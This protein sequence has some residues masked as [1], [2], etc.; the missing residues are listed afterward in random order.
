MKNF[1]S[2]PNKTS[3]GCYYRAQNKTLLF[4]WSLLVLMNSYCSSPIA[5]KGLHGAVSPLSSAAFAGSFP[6][7]S[8]KYFFLKILSFIAFL[9]PTPLK[10]KAERGQHYHKANIPRGYSMSSHTNTIKY[11][12]VYIPLYQIK[13]QY[14]FLISFM[15]Y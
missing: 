12:F 10:S 3:F 9:Y 4:D 11:P 13:K 8:H 15:I 7:F 5:P 2:F 14:L 6:H 1:I